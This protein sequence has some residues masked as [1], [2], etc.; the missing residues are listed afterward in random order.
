MQAKSPTEQ[1]EANHDTVVS[2][3]GSEIVVVQAAPTRGATWVIAVSLVVIATCLVLRLDSWG[4]PTALGQPVSRSGARGIFAFT[5]QLSQGTFGVFMVDV[6]TSTLWCYEVLPSKPLLKLVA[7][8]SWKYDRYL[9]EFNIDP[10]TS[11]AVIEEMVEQQR[12]RRLQS[13]GG[14]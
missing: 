8:R 2:A 3:K 9:E 4:G 11:P 5:G 12:Q 10:D 13:A 6:D 7:A 14:P 1:S